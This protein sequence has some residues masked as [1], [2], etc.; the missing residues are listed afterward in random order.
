MLSHLSV[1]PRGNSATNVNS[2]IYGF[3]MEMFL[4]VV[5]RK[6]KTFFSNISNGEIIFLG[7]GGT[8]N[9]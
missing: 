5:R 1:S 6:S 9:M 8:K 3:K 2:M 4:V 7:C